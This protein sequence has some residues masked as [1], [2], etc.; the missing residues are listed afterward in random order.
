MPDSQAFTQSLELARTGSDYDAALNDARRELQWLRDQ[1]ASSALELL[2]LPRR[3]DDLAAA[4]ALVPKFLE[5]ST[6]IVVLGIG[7]SSLGGR[8]LAELRPHGAGPRI[9]FTDNPD[10]FSYGEAL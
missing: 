9:A 7:G 3:T 1:Y 4:D 10:P 5:N 2:G 8:A 6:D